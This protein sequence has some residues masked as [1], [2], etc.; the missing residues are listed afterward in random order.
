M[1]DNES[2]R[3]MSKRYQS[4]VNEPKSLFGRLS[5]QQWP[6]GEGPSKLVPAITVSRMDGV[7]KITRELP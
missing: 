2:W 1:E 5:L 7:E 4:Q 3:R 6:G